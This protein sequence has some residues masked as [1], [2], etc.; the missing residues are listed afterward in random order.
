MLKLSLK[1]Y[2]SATR[3]GRSV[4]SCFFV[5]VRLD[6]PVKYVKETKKIFS[7]YFKLVILC[8]DSFS[9]SLYFIVCTLL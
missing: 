8:K 5:F 9:M 1:V 6:L 4:Q 7:V 3:Y 2:V